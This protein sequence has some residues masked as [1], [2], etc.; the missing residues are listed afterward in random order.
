MNTTEMKKEEVTRAAQQHRAV[1]PVLAKCESHK[2]SQA[3]GSAQRGKDAHTG[4]G[5]SKD[6]G[7]PQLPVSN[8]HPSQGQ[9]I[10]VLLPPSWQGQGWHTAGL[11]NYL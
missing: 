7:I 10:S 1:Q 8:S 4:P 2:S 5:Q 9:F 3:E 11:Q 6:W